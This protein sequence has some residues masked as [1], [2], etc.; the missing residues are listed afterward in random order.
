MK[1]SHPIHSNWLWFYREVEGIL[2]LPCYWK[3]ALLTYPS[4]ILTCCT[5]LSFFF[6]I[7]SAFSYIF[8]CFPLNFTTTWLV[9][10]ALPSHITSQSLPVSLL[11]FSSSLCHCFIPFPHFLCVL[12]FP[13]STTRWCLPVDNKPESVQRLHIAGTAAKPEPVGAYGLYLHA[14]RHIP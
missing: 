7:S 8:L 9:L 4:D 3:L 12:L 5:V 13:T 1:L 6:Q 2:K 11:Q 14:G 10:F